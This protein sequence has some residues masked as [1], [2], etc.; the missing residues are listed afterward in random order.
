M[1]GCYV[2]DMHDGDRYLVILCFFMVKSMRMCDEMMYYIE[3]VKFTHGTGLSHR[4][5]MMSPRTM[6][7]QY[8]Q[9][10]RTI[11]L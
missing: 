3:L 11:G 9:K 5:V 4:T 2:V 1:D 7:W 10:L 8:N 6:R